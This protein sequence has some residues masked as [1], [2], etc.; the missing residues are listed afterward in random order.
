MARS[1][2]MKKGFLMVCAILINMLLASLTYA[3]ELTGKWQGELVVGQQLVPIIFNVTSKEGNLSATMD[4]PLQG[5]TGI[6]V[7]SVEVKQNSVTFDIKVAGARYV[8][9]LKNDALFGKW[10]QS[11]QEFELAMSKGNKTPIKKK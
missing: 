11:G 5:A 7:E 3:Q 2:T 6:P 4:S 8:A 9:E 10:K 1:N